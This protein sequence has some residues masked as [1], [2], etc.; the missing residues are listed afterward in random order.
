MD[1]PLNFY[2][3]LGVSA[4]INVRARSGL[5]HH[6]HSGEQRPPAIRTWTSLMTCRPSAGPGGRC[7]C[8]AHPGIP[9]PRC[10]GGIVYNNGLMNVLQRRCQVHRERGQEEQAVHAD[11][12]EISLGVYL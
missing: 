11:Y 6:H 2:G 9:A 8:G 12:L 10:S 7:R 3:Q 1:Q 5:H 4:A